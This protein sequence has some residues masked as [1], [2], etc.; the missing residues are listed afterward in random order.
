MMH[1]Y[2]YFVFQIAHVGLKLLVM[3]V[4]V[5][6]WVF[7][8]PGSF[9]KATDSRKPAW[10]GPFDCAT[11]QK[12]ELDDH[13]FSDLLAKQRILVVWGLAA[14]C[15]PLQTDVDGSPAPPHFPIL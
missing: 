6:D 13:L 4:I 7:R 3:A 1:T 12:F 2:R 11:C 15:R 5:F 14:P 10:R 8:N 9:K